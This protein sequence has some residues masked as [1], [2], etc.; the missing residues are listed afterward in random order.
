VAG[1]RVLLTPSAPVTV[2]GA[3]TI[4]L[5]VTRTDTGRTG[6]TTSTAVKGSRFAIGVPR[7][8]RMEAGT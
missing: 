5:T 6:A 8:V 1:T 3:D 7:A 2:P 4:T